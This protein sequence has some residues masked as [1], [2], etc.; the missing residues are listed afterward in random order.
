MGQEHLRRRGK[1]KQE[2]K[3]MKNK[4]KKLS[5]AMLSDKI[6]FFFSI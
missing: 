5:I 6:H 4:I 1:K 2:K 3:Q